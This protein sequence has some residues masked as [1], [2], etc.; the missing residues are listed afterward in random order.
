MGPNA[1]IGIVFIPLRRPG[2][3]I[4]TLLPVPRASETQNTKTHKGNEKMFAMYKVW[5]D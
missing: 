3:S 4:L 2:V 5:G 1:A